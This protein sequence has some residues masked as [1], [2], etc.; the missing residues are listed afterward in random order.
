MREKWDIQFFSP[1]VQSN[2]PCQVFLASRFML[3]TSHYA[4]LKDSLLRYFYYCPF[5]AWKYKFLFFS[6]R[7][8]IHIIRKNH[9]SNYGCWRKE[10]GTHDLSAKSSECNGLSITRLFIY[11]IILNTSLSKFGRR[12]ND[13]GM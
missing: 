11:F 1:S 10:M 7:K 9:F 2:K 6:Q 12:R 5:K 13:M 8:Y 3:C 4:L